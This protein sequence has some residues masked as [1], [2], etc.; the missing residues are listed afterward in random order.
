[1]TY[2]IYG[3]GFPCLTQSEWAGWSQAVASIVAIGVAIWLGERQHKRTLDL[4]RDE[5]ERLEQERARDLKNSA[6]WIASCLIDTSK[7]AKQRV[8]L[9]QGLA[10]DS[11]DEKPTAADVVKLQAMLS[12]FKG[13]WELQSPYVLQAIHKLDPEIA[14][15]ISQTVRAVELY[16][17]GLDGISQLIG[18][19][20]ISFKAFPPA[21]KTATERAAKIEQKAKSAYD[22]LVKSLSIPMDLED[23][24]EPPEGQKNS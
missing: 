10:I 20:M 6:I 9:I 12:A 16:C 3:L 15:P 5:R 2:C 4:V 24:K 21:L 11:K 1:M 22:L 13:R 19:Q 17:S 7:R 23:D 8:D 18:S 14:S